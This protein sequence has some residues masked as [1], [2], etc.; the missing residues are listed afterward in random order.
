MVTDQLRFGGPSGKIF[1]LAMEVEFAGKI[2]E[3]KGELSIAMFDYWMVCWHDDEHG[4]WFQ[5][6]FSVKKKNNDDLT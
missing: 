6:C 1:A 5:T 4:W 3:G 2:I